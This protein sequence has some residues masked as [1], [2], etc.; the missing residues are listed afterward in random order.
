[1]EYTRLGSTG[2]RVSKLCFGT[3]R[4]NQE[5][6]GDVETDRETA[7]DLLDAAWDAGINYIDT[8]NGY[9]GGKA[10]QWIGEWM[11]ERGIDRPHENEPTGKA[12]CDNLC[13]A[14]EDIFKHVS[15]C[16]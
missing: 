4:F 1:M 8:A 10:E 12:N 2:L 7:F 6:D 15:V 14:F 16:N 11:D 9:G 13:T 5:S 3:W